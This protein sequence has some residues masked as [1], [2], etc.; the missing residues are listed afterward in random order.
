MAKRLQADNA[1]Q[2]RPNQLTPEE[3]TQRLN[4]AISAQL[5]LDR[6]RETFNAKLREDR[7]ENVLSVV[8]DVLGMPTTTFSIFVRAAKL[9]ADES[10]QVAWDDFKNHLQIGTAALGIGE[11]LSL[12]DDVRGGMK[13]KGGG[14]KKT[15]AKTATRGRR[16]PGKSTTGA[17]LI[18]E[19][20]TAF[21]EAATADTVTEAKAKGAEAGSAG[22]DLA[23][24][25]YKPG[26]KHSQG[27]AAGWHKAQA[28][29]AAGIGKTPD[30]GANETTH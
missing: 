28:A 25:P 12:F 10:N 17:K 9:K 3:M 21:A 14:K 4:D 8:R 11:Q 2:V 22:K 24:N 19:T 6:K 26:T 23:T 30:R 20:K 5:E 13:K 15:E 18:E 27:Y 29:I 7:N 16:Q 1:D